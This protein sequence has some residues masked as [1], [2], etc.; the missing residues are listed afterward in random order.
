M[1]KK[2]VAN[3]TKVTVENVNDSNL[4]TQ[5]DVERARN[6]EPPQKYDA[7]LL[8]EDQDAELAARIFHKMQDQYNLKVT[9]NFI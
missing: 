7:Y 9:N 6:G 1:E 3:Q 2:D 5:T 4:L 8:Y